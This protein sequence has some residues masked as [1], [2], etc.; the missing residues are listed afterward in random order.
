MDTELYKFMINKLYE[1]GL[2]KRAFAEEHGIPHAW[3]IEFI[4]PDKVFRPM[5][6]KTK[7][8][9]MREFGIDSSMVD[10]YNN[11]VY[12]ERRCQDGD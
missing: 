9:L 1:S 11:Y 6:V 12:D 2:S 5:Q 8:L 7:S 3:F 10:A 4:N